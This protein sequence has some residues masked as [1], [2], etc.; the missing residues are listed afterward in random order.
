M[1]VEQYKWAHSVLHD[2]GEKY[3]ITPKLV[4]GL[5]NL[6]IKIDTDKMSAT[7]MHNQICDVAKQLEQLEP[8]ISNDQD[9]KELLQLIQHNNP[10][11][12]A[13]DHA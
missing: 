4:K 8:M 11:I 3:V 13:V 12:K 5:S 6:G 7:E 9:F 10:D 2:D 1:T